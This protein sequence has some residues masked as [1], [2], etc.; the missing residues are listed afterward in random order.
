MITNAPALGPRPVHA[1]LQ[2]QSS[3]AHQIDV[4]T[5]QATGPT[6]MVNVYMNGTLGTPDMFDQMGETLAQG[7]VT[8]YAIG[9]R[10][11]SEWL[12]RQRGEHL[13]LG[14]YADDVEAVVRRAKQE[15]PGSPVRV[16]GTSFG[17]TVVQEWNIHHNA[18][19]V[20]VLALSPVTLDTFMPLGQ[21]PAVFAALLG[22]D[23]AAR[24]LLDT[25]MSVG[26]RM[27]DNPQSRYNTDPAMHDLHV[28][29]GFWRDDL[30][31]NADILRHH[32]DGRGPLQVVLA[33]ADAVNNNAVA[34]LAARAAGAQVST[35]AGAAH[36]L[37]Q[38][39]GSREVVRTFEQFLR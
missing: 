24:K 13:D 11:G 18:D 5:T 37:S 3:D 20:P 1:D 7:G 39:V 25:P 14:R 22:N 21:R 9:S 35:I 4:R 38:E 15:H 10:T 33:G 6:R 30:A 12:E 34:K 16:I 2:L 28:P 19:R 36:D 27:S 8:S 32:G 29:A 26:V 31:M 23:A 17:G